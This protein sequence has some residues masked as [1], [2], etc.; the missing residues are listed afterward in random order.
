MFMLMHSRLISGPHCKAVS[1]VVCVFLSIG[2]SLII[3]CFNLHHVKIVTSQWLSCCCHTLTGVGVALFV[4]SIQDFFICF[5]I[6]DQDNDQ[7]LNDKEIYRFQVRK[8]KIRHMS[9]NVVR[10]YI[11]CINRDDCS[12]LLQV[13]AS[14]LIL[15]LDGLSVSQY[16]HV[17]EMWL[18][19]I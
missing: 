11:T 14:G 17:N 5:Q 3:I 7:I 19:W 9:C 2:V 16:Y 12:L 6:C 10:W 15:D 18:L 1:A 13:D 8:Y 4:F